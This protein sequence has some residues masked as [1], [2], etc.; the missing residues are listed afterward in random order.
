MSRALH[1]LALVCGL[2]LLGPAL[3]APA[4]H[5]LVVRIA[6]GAQG[7]PA[8]SIVEL[9]VREAGRPERRL[10]LAGGAA[11]PA[12]STRTVAV[13]LTEPLDPETVAR[14]SIY[15]RG[16]AS[17]PLS[18]WEIS[19]A[20][21]LASSA[22]GREVPL[23]A[24]I[25]GLVRGEG[26]ISSAER[27]ASSLMCVTDA[28][29]DDGRLCNGRERCD[30]RAHNADARGCVAG[31]PVS[32]PTNQVCIERQGCRGTD[33]GAPTKSPAAAGAT[34][35]PP[36]P[37]P[38]SEHDATADAK[39]APPLQTCAGH[40]VLLTAANGAVRPE[41]CPTGTACVPQPNGTGICAPAR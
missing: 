30:P 21:V 17:A 29:C 36:A 16:P 37:P 35:W 5:R 19:N 32:C 2:A 9:R 25:Q 40:N 8:G 11:W 33:G 20:Q 38:A 4:V 31:V 18:A 28:D 7:A 23:G 27:A 1:A 13:S 34:A 26:E 41:Q 3:G 22:D 39:R 6:T 14:F 12:G 10:P 24:P 15:Y